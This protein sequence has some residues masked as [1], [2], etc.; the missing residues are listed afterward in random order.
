FGGWQI[1][2]RRGSALFQLGPANGVSGGR[3]SASG[4]LRATVSGFPVSTTHVVTSG[5]LGVGASKRFRGVKWEV[6]G[7]IVLRWFITIPISALLAWITFKA[8]EI[9]FL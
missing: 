2:R 1:R 9:L 5:I 8:I 4:V 7:K 3:C 6:A